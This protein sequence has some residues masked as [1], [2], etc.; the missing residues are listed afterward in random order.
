MPS[1]PLLPPPL[2]KLL[3]LLRLVSFEFMENELL[4]LVHAPIGTIGVVDVV[5]SVARFLDDVRLL[6]ELFACLAVFV[7]ARF[8]CKYGGGRS[9]KFLARGNFSFVRLQNKI[10][11]LES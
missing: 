3:L 1:A 5:E 11:K 6:L 10:I 8:E 2:K 9:E 7:G 4:L